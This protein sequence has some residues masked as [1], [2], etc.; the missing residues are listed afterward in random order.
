MGERL[1]QVTINGRQLNSG[2]EVTLVKSVGRRKGR[3]RFDWAEHDTKGNMILNVFGPLRS[4]SLPHY[5]LAAISA[6][7]TVHS[8][9][10]A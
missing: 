1:E 10:K 4:R 2:M 6:V 8:K 5:R 7:E 3:Y 9:T